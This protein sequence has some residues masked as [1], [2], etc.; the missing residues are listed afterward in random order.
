MKKLISILLALSLLLSL[1]A[2]GPEEPQV[3]GNFYYYRLETVYGGSDG[4]IVPEVRELKDIEHD[5]GAILDLYCQG[6]VS[7]ELECILPQG[8]VAQGWY[9]DGKKLTIRLSS[10]FAM[11]TGVELTIACACLT[12]TMLELTEATSVTINAGGSLLD[13]QSAITMTADQLSLQDDSLERL[14]AD[15]TVYYADDQRRYLIGQSISMSLTDRSALP[16]MLLEQMLQ[17]P[18]NSGLYSVL[19]Y[20]TRIR[21]VS[22]DDGLCTVD[23]SQEFELDRLS[24]LNAQLLSLIGVVNTLTQLDEI[25]QVEFAVEGSLLI[26]Y[27]ELRIS[28][29]MT[30]DDRFLGPVR[31]ALGEQ[32]ITLYLAHGSEQ[33]LVP[34]PFRLRRTAA[35]SQEEL[36]LL[37]LLND[38]GNNDF[39][40]CIPSGTQLNSIRVE[41]GI[42]HIDLSAEYLSEPE[43]LLWAGRVIA[44]SVCT[45]EQIL[46]VN[47]TVEGAV[48]EDLDRRLFGVL[49][50]DSDWFL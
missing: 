10:E 29:P 15:F 43:K 18:E 28:G 20:G 44:A 41:N 12:R 3:P 25:D 11:L 17:P 27:G 24:T 40:S 49:A 30:S 2:C 8:T 32:D 19:P 47:I 7:R 21:S 36:I 14:R 33:L 34:I 16:Q 5:I 26:R 39:S 50:P 22:V 13:G 37:A 42:C 35:L 48:P 6:P 38:S 45:S 4:V 9:L 1:T 23:L 31:T 46:A